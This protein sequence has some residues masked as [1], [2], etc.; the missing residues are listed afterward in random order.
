[1][2]PRKCS[3]TSEFLHQYGLTQIRPELLFT[4]QYLFTPTLLP[5]YFIRIIWSPFWFESFRTKSLRRKGE[6]S[7]PS[8]EGGPDPSCGNGTSKLLDESTSSLSRKTY[9]KEYKEVEF[10]NFTVPRYKRL[11]NKSWDN[12]HFSI[13]NMSKFL[14]VCYS[15]GRFRNVDK[16]S[17]S[18]GLCKYLV[19][20]NLLTRLPP[21]YLKVSS[22]LFS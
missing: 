15:F 5:S 18:F 7:V 4:F 3:F 1:M 16:V 22:S 13:E 21:F 14:V 2:N 11:W 17:S 9:D 20:I 10:Y 12:S 19:L 8:K 6:V